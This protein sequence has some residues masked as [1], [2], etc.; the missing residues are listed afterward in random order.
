MHNL[1]IQ[2]VHK[3]GE[4]CQI[5]SQ[6]NEVNFVPFGRNKVDLVPLAYED[7]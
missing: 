5:S 3:S 7:Y 1:N 2:T 6:V 4:S